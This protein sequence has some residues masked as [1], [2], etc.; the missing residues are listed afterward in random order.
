MS[1][2]AQRCRTEST[3]LA[4]ELTP[5]GPASSSYS[6]VATV[7]GEKVRYHNLLTTDPGTLAFRGL[8]K[9]HYSY[10]LWARENGPYVLEDKLKSK[11]LLS[12]PQE[13]ATP[14]LVLVDVGPELLSRNDKRDA[15]WL[16]EEAR[17]LAMLA[18][19]ADEPMP[20]GNPLRP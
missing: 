5:G 10:H 6:S 19:M 8:F 15:S 2:L 17:M 9:A 12:V 1:L 18:E 11:Q 14:Q 16:A 13:E 20:H 7:P 4:K 3:V